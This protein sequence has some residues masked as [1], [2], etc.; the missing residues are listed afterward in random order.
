MKYQTDFLKFLFFFL[1]LLPDSHPIKRRTRSSRTSS[2]IDP[3]S[4]NAAINTRRTRSMTKDLTRPSANARSRVTFVVAQDILES[5]ECGEDHPAAQSPKQQPS[6]TILNQTFEIDSKDVEDS[7]NCGDEET[8]VVGEKTTY[9]VEDMELTDP[10]VSSEEPKQQETVIHKDKPTEDKAKLLT[11]DISK[12][13]K[14]SKNDTQ[15]LKKKS[16]LPMK[17][18]HAKVSIKKKDFQETFQSPKSPLMSPGITKS[19]NGFSFRCVPSPVF[20]RT[21]KRE[22]VPSRPHKADLSVT[23]VF[24]LSE[25][26]TFTEAKSILMPPNHEPVIVECDDGKTGFTEENLSPGKNDNDVSDQRKESTDDS[27]NKKKSS[28]LRKPKE[29]KKATRV[30]KR[31][32]NAAKEHSSEAEEQNETDEIITKKDDAIERKINQRSKKSK[33]VVPPK[34]NISKTEQNETD[35]I[36]TKKDDGIEPKINQRSRKSKAIV[37]PKVNI[38]KTHQQGSDSESDTNNHKKGRKKSAFFPFNEQGEEDA[39]TFFITKP[40]IHKKK[41]GNSTSKNAETD[42]SPGPTVNDKSVKFHSGDI[43]TDDQISDILQDIEMIPE[44]II[45]ETQTGN[46]N[47]ETKKRGKKKQKLSSVPL[48]QNALTTVNDKQDLREPKPEVR[49]VKDSETSNVESEEPPVKQHSMRRSSGSPVIHQTQKGR[50]RRFKIESDTEEEADEDVDPIKPNRR[51]SSA[52]AGKQRRLSAAQR[53]EQEEGDDSERVSDRHK[54]SRSRGRSITR[55]QTKPATSE[56]ERKSEVDMASAKGSNE[57]GQGELTMVE[58]E[59]KVEE[60]VNEDEV[61][62]AR[63]NKRQEKGQNGKRKSKK[64]SATEMSKGKKTV[65]IASNDKNDDKLLQEVNPKDVVGKCETSARN[66][67]Q[68]EADNAEKTTVPVEADRRLTQCIKKR[69]SS[70]DQHKT[71]LQRISFQKQS[72]GETAHHE[73]KAEDLGGRRSSRRAAGA[74]NYCEPKIGR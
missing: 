27:N 66:N 15:G 58:E 64:K 7:Q 47:K 43:L 69:S 56:D 51:S 55:K 41:K 65:T 25:G 36:I 37:P 59:E 30:N 10:L 68:S 63:N 44:P 11:E 5:S 24:D 35:E 21:A 18:A 39:S 67:E 72:Q 71:K 19:S 34:V 32:D 12:A 33:T 17:K 8:K 62:K 38:S 74:I 28:K 3:S 57:G 48:V 31:K 9:K 61:V 20:G 26:D 70:S 4:T 42:V 6:T 23:S 52:R 54:R 14:S 13:A 22:A 46:C 49:D 29:I 1:L 40:M 50:K 60:I 53:G 73:N 45:P 16:K 2:R